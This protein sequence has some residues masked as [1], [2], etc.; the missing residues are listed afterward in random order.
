MPDDDFVTAGNHADNDSIDFIDSFAQADEV[1]R[2]REQLVASGPRFVDET[3]GEIAKAVN[4][5]EQLKE[6]LI[7]SD[8]SNWNIQLARVEEEPSL[9]GETRYRLTSTG[10]D[11]WSNEFEQLVIS[12]NEY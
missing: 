10:F 5:D 7:A 9:Y 8:M 2:K 6:G 12:V 1:N 4:Y 3:I 11:A